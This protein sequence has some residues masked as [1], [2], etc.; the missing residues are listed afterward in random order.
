MIIY[1]IFGIAFML[2]GGGFLILAI[3]TLEDGEYVP[4][5]ACIFFI[6]FGTALAAHTI[7]K[8]LLY[9][10]LKKT[11]ELVKAGILDVIEYR[12]TGKGASTYYRLK[13][14]YRGL[15]FISDHLSD[16]QRDNAQ[17]HRTV[18]VYLDKN[19]PDKKYFVDLESLEN[20]K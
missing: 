11:G 15:T 8:L 12:T 13:A 2:M 20:V 10:R 6:V 18:D 7:Y 3:P 1:L 5:A 14:D 19:K 4:L 17:R 16:E 9:A